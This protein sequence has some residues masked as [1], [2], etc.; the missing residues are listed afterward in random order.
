[1]PY[2]LAWTIVNWRTVGN[3]ITRIGLVAVVVLVV[4]DWRTGWRLWDLAGGWIIVALFAW[5]VVLYTVRLKMRDED[6]KE[7]MRQ[8]ARRQ[9][10]REI[11]ARERDADGGA[12]A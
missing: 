11:E 1:M 6:R 2:W 5:A 12:D 10:Q 4:Y 3:W 8:L 9:E 7:E